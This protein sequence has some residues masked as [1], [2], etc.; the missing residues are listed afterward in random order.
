MNRRYLGRV[1]SP[2]TDVPPLRGRAREA[3]SNDEAILLA[4]H[5]VFSEYGWG[6][7]MAEVAARAHTGVASI[8][9]RYPSKT[10]LVNAIRE[11]T[12]EQ[13]CVRAEE[14][15]AEARAAH[16][17]ISAVALFLRGHIL[18]ATAPM[19]VTFGRYVETTPQIDQLG[20]RLHAALL[21]IVAVD[22]ELGLIPR[23]YGP[24]DVMLT[25]THLRPSL[26]VAPERAI[27]IHLRELD[28]VLHGLRAVAAQ[29]TPVSG[30]PSNWQEWLR[31]N[32][33]NGGMASERA[34]D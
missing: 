21:D 5:D 3:Q 22:H 27:E 16:P 19:G 17:G 9:R 12:L 28:Y 15:V 20:E 30:E 26:A 13:I 32:S 2:D 7:P 33:T 8:Y 18:S 6:A 24:A 23:H 29:N 31:L 1:S 11:L 25:I 34:A 14:C 4:A 10:E